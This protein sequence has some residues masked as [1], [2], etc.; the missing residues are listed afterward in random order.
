MRTTVIINLKGGV[1]KTSTTINMAAVL[2][3]VF[4][5]HVLVIDADAQ[6]NATEFLGGNPLVGNLAN[7]LRRTEMD[8]G[9][10]AVSQIQPSNIPNVDLLAGDETLMDL[11]LTKVEL[12]SVRAT[13][14]RDMIKRLEQDDVY[15]C[16]LVDCPPAFNAASAA[17]LIAAD[18]AIIP[19]KLDAFSLRGMTCLLR[20]IANMKKINPCLRLSGCLPTMYYKSTTILAAEET[21]RASGIPV[22]SPIRRTDKVDEM[23]FSQSPLLSCS[24][25]SA[26]ARDYC[27]FVREYCAG[28]KKNG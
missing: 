20:Q 14:L 9:K 11:D 10:F 22:F 5:K 18:D 3:K 13:V 23:T 26:A 12:K 4:D 1:A 28:G 2:A 17:A 21:L 8:H 15:D 19:I 7:V 6:S 24:P 25:R 27:R 16:V